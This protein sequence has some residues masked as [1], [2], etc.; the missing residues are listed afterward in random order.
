M[1]LDDLLKKK[2]IQPPT[3]LTSNCHFLTIHGSIAYGTN[4]DTSDF[5]VYGWAIPK[6]EII[7]PHLNGEIEGFGKQKQRFDQWCQ[8]GILDKE[9][10]QDGRI[11]DF[12]VYGIVRFFQLCMENNPN[13]LETLF[14]ASDCILHIT[15][16]ANII[17]DNRY[18]FLHKGIIPKL[19]GYAHSQLKKAASPNKVGKRAERVRQLGWDAKHLSHV[20][21]LALQ[22]EDVLKFHDL[23]LRK[24]RE[25]VKAVKRG[26]ISLDEVKK[27]FNEQE[28][29]LKKLE[30]E[31]TLPWGPNE[32]KI[33]QLLIDCL[34]HHFGSLEKCVVNLDKDKNTLESIID[35]LKSRDYV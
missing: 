21:R 6:K 29:L 30:P 31:S 7:F 18:L 28:V 24:H 26:D 19:S 4:S 3:W 27:W 35:L 10:Q 34:E 33:K 23:D 32:P 11:Y 9:A 8:H 5:D 20:V 14:T 22:A 17:R 15:S 13:V 1:L 16:I 2:L 12:T 25:H